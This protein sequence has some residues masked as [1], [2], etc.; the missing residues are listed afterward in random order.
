MIWL[1]WSR[2]KRLLT[3]EIAAIQPNERIPRMPDDFAITGEQKQGEGRFLISCCAIGH[4]VIV[5][6]PFVISWPHRRHGD[7][8]IRNFVPRLDA[9]HSLG[10]HWLIIWFGNSCTASST[11]P[12]SSRQPRARAVKRRIGDP[13]LRTIWC[14]RT[15]TR[16]IHLK[17][18]SCA[19]LLQFR[20]NDW[21]LVLEGTAF[22]LWN[23][24]VWTARYVEKRT[25]VY[26]AT[27]RWPANICRDE[28]T[29]PRRISRT[30]DRSSPTVFIVDPSGCWERRF[31]TRPTTSWSENVVSRRRRRRDDCVWK[32]TPLWPRLRVMDVALAGRQQQ[33]RLSQK[34]PPPHLVA[35][36][37]FNAARRRARRR[38]S[39]RCRTTF[40]IFFKPVFLSVLFRRFSLPSFTLFSRHAKGL[41]STCQGRDSAFLISLPSF[42]L[43]FLRSWNWFFCLFYFVLHSVIDTGLHFKA[44]LRC[45][46]VSFPFRLGFFVIRWLPSDR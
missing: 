35:A 9:T 27:T 19:R 24:G 46:F 6:I 26:T 23:F 13:T 12:R 11:E 37:F 8:S 34:A 29:A 15:E 30:L 31:F 36:P 44:N 2:R 42:L 22:L 38:R 32:T 45:L 43:G 25:G 4:A 7:R 40:P 16:K 18:T 17:A 10:F 1:K 3:L 20:P 21:W 33:R 5:I 28:S 39:R 41:F 14:G